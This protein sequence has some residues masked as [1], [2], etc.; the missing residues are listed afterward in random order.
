MI[1]MSLDAMY[2]V[3]LLFLMIRRP[4][5]ST[6]TDTLFPY[7]T[8]FRSAGPGAAD[9]PY[10]P[11]G[12]PS[13][14]VARAPLCRRGGDCR[15]GRAGLHPPPGNDRWNGDGYRLRDLRSAHDTL[16]RTR[17]HPCPPAPVRRPTGLGP[18]SLPPHPRLLAHPPNSAN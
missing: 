3:I 6:R 16:C 17:L 13:P 8:L 18:P 1:F 7:T 5:R 4:P 2:V 11:R 14:P 12:S 9:R 15:R 10:T